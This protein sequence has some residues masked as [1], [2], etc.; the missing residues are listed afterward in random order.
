MSK[1]HTDKTLAVRVPTPMFNRF[2]ELCDANFKSM[3]DT[4]RD[5]IRE[6]IQTEVL[7]RYED[8][9]FGVINKGWIVAQ[10]DGETYTVDFGNIYGK[11]CK[12][13]KSF[14][15]VDAAIEVIDG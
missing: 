7:V 10:E 14:E 12:V 5:F 9:T 8:G 4:I 1:K 13:V 15:Q 6:R 3:S 11:K 2:K